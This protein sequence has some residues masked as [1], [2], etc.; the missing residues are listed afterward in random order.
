[1][2]GTG[3]N[4]AGVTFTGDRYIDGLLSD[5]KWSSANITYSFPRSNFEYVYNRTLDPA[6]STFSALGPAVQIA[7]NLALNAEGGAPAAAGFSVE[8]FTN[9]GVNYTTAANA[10][11]RLAMSNDP[12]TAYAYLPGTAA[13]DGDIWF[14]KFDYNAPQAGNYAWMTVLHEIGH[15]LGLKHGHEAPVIPADRDMMEYTV[16]SYRA[17]QGGSVTGGYPNEESGFAQTFMMYDIAAL[18][19]MY[20]ADFITNSGDTVYKWNP[21]SGNT[22]VNGSVAIT[23]GGNRILATIWDG[24]G[25]DTY[26]L[27]GYA[28]AVTIDLAPGGHSV[29][30]DVQ[31]AYLGDENTARANIFNALQFNGDARSLIEN[32][33]GGAGHDTINGNQAHNTLRGNLGNDSIQG[34]DGN[35][36][37]FGGEGA[38]RLYGEN[39]DD[40][41][42]GENGADRLEGG[43][44]SD[45][46]FGGG[47]A[48]G[49]F[50]GGGND[51]MG[52][53]DGDDVMHGEAGNDV[54]SGEAGFDTLYGL[55]GDDIMRG[56]TNAD[57][58]LGGNGTDTMYGEVGSDRLFGQFGNDLMSG[59]TD[60][61]VLWGGG[62]FDK[63]Y[64][65]AGDDV[66]IGNY[67][68]D[69]FFF[70][71]MFGDDVILDFE[72]L[73]TFEKIDLSAIVSIVDFADLA[74]SHMS[75]AGSDV[76]ID[77]LGGN[78]IT[79]R[80][81]SLADLDATNFLF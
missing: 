16:M 15:A 21:L 80:N 77:D 62:G 50:G 79:L 3:T 36:T 42:Y 69:T 65:D 59:G 17:Y 39:D 29:F 52:G 12:E 4:S 63:L 60:N 30:S 6:P 35:D 24:G 73:N 41:L 75:Q 54:I 38:D 14:N 18:Q 1:M 27:S 67:N 34:R 57:T 23:A 44:G 13:T 61:D 8:G 51:V 49:M 70:A 11:L 47:S 45:R 10:T 40:T 26:D 76:L 64:G 19:H 71:G 37:L 46:M 81:V 43:L 74:A 31:L 68:W 58:I 7:A 20:G 33:T 22:L 9:L 32:A 78:T 56:G 53:G 55:D 28:N 25:V 48:D 72:A 66:L 2:A 5:S